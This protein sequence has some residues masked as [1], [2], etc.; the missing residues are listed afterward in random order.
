METIHIQT[1]IK[2]PIQKVWELYNSP[3][4]ITK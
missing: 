4:A 2:A 1:T 3:D